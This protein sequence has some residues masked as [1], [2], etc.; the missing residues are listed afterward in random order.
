SAEDVAFVDHEDLVIDAVD[1]D[2]VRVGQPGGGTADAAQ[3]FAGPRPKKSTV[4][5]FWNVPAT[6]SLRGSTLQPQVRFSVSS[7]A[8]KSATRSGARWPFAGRV[9]HGAVRRVVA[10]CPELVAG[11]VDHEGRRIV[12]EGREALDRAQRRSR[13]GRGTRVHE[14]I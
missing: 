10:D 12:E 11:G 7:R 2:A 14:R 5:P 9:D 8:W 3:R 1:D 13:A 4:E 6:S